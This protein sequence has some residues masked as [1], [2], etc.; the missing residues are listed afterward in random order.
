MVFEGVQRE[1]KVYEGQGVRS[2]VED[3]VKPE[4]LAVR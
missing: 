3:K 4:R 2:R 1:S